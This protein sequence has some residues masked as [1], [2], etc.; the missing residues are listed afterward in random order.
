MQDTYLYT[1]Q[2]QKELAQQMAAMKSHL[3]KEVTQQ[4]VAKAKLT[5]LRAAMTAQQAKPPFT[6][7][8]PLS[9]PL[10]K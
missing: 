10:V 5:E 7:P 8:A 2:G 9:N 4:Q 3:D 1:T 6:T